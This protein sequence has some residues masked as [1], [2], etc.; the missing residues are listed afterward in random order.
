MD[1]ARWA[2]LP[3]CQLIWN[4]TPD[5]NKADAVYL[6]LNDPY[7]EVLNNAP[8]R[9]LDY[10][11]LK[12]LAPAAQRF[13]EIVSYKIFAA[14]KFKLPRAKLPYSDYCTFSAQQR[15]YDYDHVKKQMYKIHKPHLA[16]GYIEKVSIKAVPDGDGK[17]DWIMSYIPGPKARAEFKT[18]NGKHS[19]KGDTLDPDL[20]VPLET[21][22]ASAPDNAR[23]LV[24]YFHRRFH[25]DETATPT[26][27]DLK[28]AAEL[29]EQYGIEKSRFVVEYSQEAAASTKYKP[30]QLLGI[31]KY[32]DAAIQTFDT[33]EKNRQEEKRKAREEEL[34][35]Q[36]ERYRDHE[37]QRIK[38]SLS[39]D[40]LAKMEST[41]RVDLKA[42]GIKQFAHGLET[43]RRMDKKLAA[44]ASVLPYEEWRK[45]Q[46]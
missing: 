13:Y 4:T 43:S 42:E 38:S 37:I 10:D 19:R 3:V 31:R 21:S 27:K 18:F 12:Q 25:H 33:R 11:Y 24:Q 23:N 7:R 15:Y 22:Q 29:V 9:P 2:I 16:S 20:V 35:I 5:G 28:F 45:Q 32:V 36:Y 17:P 8:T 14:L 6:I 34:Q 39:P 41:I 46:A 40:E 30:D 26:A 44:R 1:N